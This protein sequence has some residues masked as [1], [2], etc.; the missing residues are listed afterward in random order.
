MVSDK[1][2]KKFQ[3]AMKA[4]RGI[5]LSDKE[6]KEVLLNWVGFFDLLTKIYHRTQSDKSNP[7]S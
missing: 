3:E 6:A 5:V 2:I 7:A 1:T 4:E